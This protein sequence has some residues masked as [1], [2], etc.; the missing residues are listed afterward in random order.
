MLRKIRISEAKRIFSSGGM[1]GLCP[2]KMR[3]DGPFS[4]MVLCSGKDRIEHVKLICGESY[5]RDEKHLFSE[6]WNS[7]IQDWKHYNSSHE[8]GYYP[9][10]YVEESG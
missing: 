1:V 9:H 6:A 5:F 8:C 7:L 2:R 3:P 10:F 4:M